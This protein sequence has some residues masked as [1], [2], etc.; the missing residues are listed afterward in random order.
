MKRFTKIFLSLIS[1]SSSIAFAQPL[2]ADLTI[3]NNTDLDSVS[4]IHGFCTY[5]LIGTMGITKPHTTQTIPSGRVQIACH[6]KT[7]KCEALVFLNN[8]DSCSA[9]NAPVAKV[10]IDLDNGF[11]SA[12]MYD[13]AYTVTGSKFVISINKA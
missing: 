11:D 2:T 8:A 7:G 12:E 9:P 10:I 5:P 13:P 4:S 1:L 3:T 6:A